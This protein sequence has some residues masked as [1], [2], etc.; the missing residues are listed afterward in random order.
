MAWAF[1]VGEAVG[2]AVALVVGVVAVVGGFAPRLRLGP[3]PGLWVRGSGPSFDD[4]P[5]G[6]RYPARAGPPSARRVSL[7]RYLGDR[8]LPKE[9]ALALHH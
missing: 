9:A 1:F 5:K 3:W 4:S 7:P 6:D 8:V 2:E